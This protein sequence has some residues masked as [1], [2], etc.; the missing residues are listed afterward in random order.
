MT[1]DHGQRQ[2]LACQ[3]S[4]RTVDDLIEVNSNINIAN[5]ELY[6]DAIKILISNG[7]ILKNLKNILANEVILAYNVEGVQGKAALR[8]EDNFFGIMIDSITA[9]G[10]IGPAEDQLRKALQLQKKRD[11]LKTRAA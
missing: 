7:G 11:I 1:K 8:K 6:I 5:R 10:G 4:I 3:F 2:K 9:V